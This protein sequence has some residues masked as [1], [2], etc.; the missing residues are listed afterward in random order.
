[1]TF[2]YHF[3]F[4]AKPRGRSFSLLLLAL[5]IFFGLMLLSHGIQKWAAFHTLSASFPDP[6]GISSQLSLA[7]AIFGELFCSMFF[8]I[9]FLYRLVTIPMI[10]TMAVAFF[11]VHGGSISHGELA[12][13]Y[14]V[15]LVILY[16]TGPG[17]FSIDRLITRNQ[18]TTYPSTQQST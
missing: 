2:I 16:I 1:M 17:R 7:L 5:R 3:L 14:M 12:F 11:T 15:M 4:P 18:F 13:V 9:G 8:I 6:L 10:V